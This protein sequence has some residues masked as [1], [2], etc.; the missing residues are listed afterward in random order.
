[1]TRECLMTI[2]KLPEESERL[3]ILV[4][5]RNEGRGTVF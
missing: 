3:I 5:Y 2:G 1:M 4:D